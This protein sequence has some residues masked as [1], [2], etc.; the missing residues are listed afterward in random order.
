MKIC[1]NSNTLRR[2]F[3]IF[4]CLYVGN[5]RTIHACT[6]SPFIFINWHCVK[7]WITL[8]S[9]NFKHRCIFNAKTSDIHF[10]H[11]C[12][13]F[14]AIESRILK[15][16]NVCWDRCAVWQSFIVVTHQRRNRY[17]NEAWLRSA[18]DSYDIR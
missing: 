18:R 3:C 2:Y 6:S 5:Y 1:I 4:H 10:Q 17:R 14:Y 8:R 9:A 13:E 11:D 7:V 15:C 16:V 12:L